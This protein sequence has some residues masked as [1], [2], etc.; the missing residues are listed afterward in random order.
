MFKNNKLFNGIKI[1]LYAAFL[2][3]LVFT[4]RTMYPWHFGKTILFMA[5]VE[6][7]VALAVVYY[8][9]RFRHSEAEDRR[10]PSQSATS[11]GSF[12]S[13]RMTVLDW[14]LI[15]FF[16]VQII[17]AAF[18]VDFT[19]SFWG[20]Q[21][22]AQGV[23]VWLHFAA[24]YF[25]LRYFLTPP[26]YKGGKGDLPPLLAKERAGVRS[27]VLM[28]WCN[29]SVW[30]FIIAV[31][32][33]LLAWL[34]PK[35]SFFNNIIGKGAQLSGM[36]GN[37][38]FFASYLIIPVFLGFALFF[39]FTPLVAGIS[40]IWI[41]YLIFGANNFTPFNK[42]GR[43]DLLPL[44]NKERVGVRSAR[45]K[46]WRIK[47]FLLAAMIL[48]F[49]S[50]GAL[51][52]YNRKSDYLKNNFPMVARVLSVSPE[53]GTAQTRLMAWQI[54]LKAWRDK[55]V[56]GWGPENYQDA[57]DKHY[58]PEFLKYSFAETVWDKPHSYPLEILA[59]TGAVGFIS[60][61]GFLVVLF[62]YLVKIIKN[63]EDEKTRFGFII[64]TGG[65]V[66]YIIQNSFAF[67]TSNSLQMWV[68]LLALVG[69]AHRHSEA[70]GRRIPLLSAISRDPS[71]A[72]PA[73]GAELRMTK[74]KEIIKN[75]FFILILLLIPCGLYKNYTFYKAS[76]LMGGARDAAE[77]GS[78][79]LWQKNAVETLNYK[80]PF[81]WE[82][83]VFLT[84]DLANIDKAGKLDKKTLDSVSPRLIEIFEN[85]IKKG[86]GPYLFRFW[87]GQLYGFMGEYVDKKYY[88]EA[89][90]ILEEAR[91]F[92]PDRQH[93][94]LLMAKNYLLRNKTDEG[95]KILE[96]LADKNPEFPEP[97]WFLGVALMQKGEEAR[98]MEELEKGKDFG[99]NFKSNVLY[100][101][102]LYAKRKEYDKIILLYKGLIT[103]EPGN[104]SY[105]ASLAATYAA[106]GDKENLITSLNKAVELNPDLAEE[107]KKFL[108]SNGIE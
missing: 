51:F 25:L 45:S 68:F 86:H 106:M 63:A 3:P 53:E 66:A 8:S 107:A 73:G 11:M 27:G 32:S 19:R 42:G 4:S 77:I 103:Q 48:G 78:A 101:I 65:A 31:I 89:D 44:L 88:G 36:I 9:R 2:L 102:D 92:S 98:G 95:I 82:Q 54:A 60:Y 67:E 81:L 39:L 22:R 55:P 75:F 29:L 52:I 12:T 79:Y 90:K 43:G 17:S 47:F 85:E 14:L 20:D 56:L 41:L 74:V 59:T 96:N 26:L 21:Q 64:L 91:E 38:I 49:L 100:L 57:F 99:V 1:G 37:P 104:A 33:S 50:L 10:I 72:S 84:K 40:V 93:I 87:L 105:H 6:I 35:I 76:V 16:A 97:H 70:E 7:L 62:F 15:I 13:F 34:G 24:F 80:I 108:K 5:L 18:G 71:S 61:L 83:A 58:N 46:N 23:F 69:E 28:N 94:P 30:I